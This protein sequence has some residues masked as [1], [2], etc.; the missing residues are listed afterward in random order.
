MPS[1]FVITDF[2]D[3]AKPFNGFHFTYGSK[4]RNK[5]EV[6][7]NPVLTTLQKQTDDFYLQSVNCVGS[8]TDHEG[9]CF[10][11]QFMCDEV[12]ANPPPSSSFPIATISGSP[13]HISHRQATV[14]NPSSTITVGSDRSL[15]TGDVNA[16]LAA[17]IC[18]PF[19]RS[20]MCA[21]SSSFYPGAGTHDNNV[22]HVFDGYCNLDTSSAKYLNPKTKGPQ[23]D[24]SIV[25]KPM[26]LSFDVKSWNDPLHPDQGFRWAYGSRYPEYSENMPPPKVGEPGG[27]IMQVVQRACFDPKD[28]SKLGT[29]YAVAFECD[30]RL[31]ETWSKS[32][33]SY[34]PQQTG[35]RTLMVR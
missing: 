34:L 23:S 35:L 9:K 15:A 14:V 20:G 6:K 25:G 13:G 3:P 7:F 17:P 4:F 31:F 11:I 32:V 28:Q 19:P 2:I 30:D 12:A 10:S 26:P 16:H 21:V 8:K 27:P 22:F 29:C 5:I 1:P 24:W 33:A 18:N